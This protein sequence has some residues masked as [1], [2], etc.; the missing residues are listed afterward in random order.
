MRG[1]P[2]FKSWTPMAFRYGTS[3]SRAAILIGFLLV[4]CAT[5]VDP[6]L[7]EARVKADAGSRSASFCARYADGCEIAVS[8]RDD[9]RW[10]ALITPITQAEDG[11]QVIGIDSDD[12][13]LYNKIGLFES[14][15]RNYE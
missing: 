8:Q 5:T 11:R 3:V 15:L 7:A 13:Y 4:G 1:A 12:F 10:G 14:A 2:Q 6:K 9:G